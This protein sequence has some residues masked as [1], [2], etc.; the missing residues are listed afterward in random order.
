MLSLVP[1]EQVLEEVQPSDDFLFVFRCSLRTEES[2]VLVEIEEVDVLF[3][4]F[5]GAD[6]ADLLEERLKLGIE[7]VRVVERVGL[8]A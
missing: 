1:L 8:A 2:H 7:D 6:E 4:T 3:A 5:V